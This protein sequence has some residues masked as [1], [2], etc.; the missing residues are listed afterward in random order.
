MRIGH[1]K[2]TGKLTFRALALVGANRGIVGCVWFVYRNM[3]LCYWFVHSNVK[4]DRSNK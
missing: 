4:G 3:E 2:E 1:C